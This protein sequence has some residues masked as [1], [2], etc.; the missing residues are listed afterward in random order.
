MMKLAINI[1][2]HFFWSIYGTEYYFIKG[3]SY[4]FLLHANI[5]TNPTFTM[6]LEYTPSIKVNSIYN[7]NG[8][9]RWIKFTPDICGEYKFL[10]STK[11]LNKD[12]LDSPSLMS[13]CTFY[14]EDLSIIETL[15]WD[16][17]LKKYKNDLSLTRYL[18]ASKEYFI[19]M[20]NLNFDYYSALIEITRK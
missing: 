10:L 20:D 14:D 6:Q 13:Y 7:F 18:E 2:I 4:Y 15:Y 3:R 5:E 1:Y 11:L 16:N 12:F 9:C 19:K 17:K 8:D